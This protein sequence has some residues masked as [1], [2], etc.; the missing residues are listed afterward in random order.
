[1]SEP[2]LCPKCGRQCDQ[3]HCPVCQAEF[4]EDWTLLDAVEEDGGQT[5]E[6]DGGETID[7]TPEEK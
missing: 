4:D 6:N 1:M 5:T 2:F 7:G 3:Q